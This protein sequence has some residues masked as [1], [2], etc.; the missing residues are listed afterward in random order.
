MSFKVLVFPGFGF[1]FCLAMLAEWIDRRMIARF[2]GRVGPP[3]FQPLADFIKL[4]GKEDLLPTG[5][6]E[7]LMAA[8][9][10]I[11]LA[12]CLTAGMYIPV[13]GVSVNN[14]EGDLIVVLFLLSLP[15]LLYFL[16]GWSSIGIY[17][18]LGGNRALLQFFSYEVPFLL[19]LSGPAILNSSWN[20]TDIMVNQS[21]S[22]WAIFVLP[23]GFMLAFFGLIGKLKRDPLDIPKAQSEIVAG[24]LTEFSGR[25]LAIWHLANQIQT[26]VG[27]F[28]LVDT[29]FGGG[30]IESRL[31]TFLL[32]SFLALLILVSLSVMSAMYARLR[33]DQLARLGWKR[34]IPLSLLQIAFIVWMGKGF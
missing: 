24:P 22:I 10:L 27:I 6:N 2:Q 25:K 31:A 12:A 7:K 1:L 29:Y 20:I 9:P 3:V 18:I 14:F 13:A 33:I 17:S 5:V 8:L 23:V 11:S 4:L 16:A 21:T 30:V 34:L 15:S 26:V 19:A 32:F 28:L